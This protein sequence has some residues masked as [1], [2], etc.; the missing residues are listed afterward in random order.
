MK[1]VTRR[2]PPIVID[3]CWIEQYAI[4]PRSIRFQ[5]HRLLFRGGREV[6][7]VPCLALGRD[8]DGKVII[9]HCD[10]RWGSRVSSGHC[11]TVREAKADAERYYPG[12]S[13]HWRKTGYTARQARRHLHDGPT[14]TRCSKRWYDVQSI[15]VIK[16]KL[17]ICD[18]CIVKLHT[19]ISESDKR[20]RRARNHMMAR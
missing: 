7:S 12:I 17:T 13:K 11:D 10:G 18:E 15:V 4:R 20:R 2:N 3:G 19:I 16:G 5:G 6:R 1:R 14:C 8:R 9:L